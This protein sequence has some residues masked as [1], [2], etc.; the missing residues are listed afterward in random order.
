MRL[1]RNSVIFIALLAIVIAVALIFLQDDDGTDNASPTAESTVASVQLFPGVAGTNVTSLTVVEQLASMDAVEATAEATEP[2]MTPEA[3][4]E[5]EMTPEA[6]AEADMSP[7]TAITVLNRDPVTASWTVGEETTQMI[8]GTISS[9]QL[10]TVVTAL[11]T[12][13]SNRQF[14]PSD[15]D[16]AQFGLD[17]PTYEITFVEQT[18]SA[19][20][21]R[22][23]VGGLT[24]GENAYYA[25]LGDDDET[26]YVITNATAF[27]TNVLNLSQAIPLEPTA[28]P[29]VAPIL[30]TLAPFADFILTAGN[31]F[32]LSNNETGDII[33]VARNA[34]NTG[35]VYTENGDELPVQ[36]ESLQVILNNFS[37]ISGIDQVENADLA[38]LG[39]DSP[40]YVFEASTVDGTIYTLQLGDQ[41]PTGSVYYG[42]V[43]NFEQVV[44]IASDSV[45]SFIDLFETQPPLTVEVTPEA[46]EAMAESTA[47][48]TEPAPEATAEM[49]EPAS[50]ATEASE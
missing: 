34:D 25:L 19:K 38:T 44:L 29:T 18:D 7:T 1:N 4:S 21:Y 23:R 36:Q 46:T 12:L 33:A 48:M 5:A 22:L 43:D 11:V 10:E 40:T 17:N 42:L 41:D 31:G 3:T 49:T 2:E 15:E 24:V 28:V 8:D 16:Y 47:E 32:T 26:I 50:E 20:T 30:N 13:R 27:Q 45:L 35:W 6:T 9:T 14:T 39:L 37:T